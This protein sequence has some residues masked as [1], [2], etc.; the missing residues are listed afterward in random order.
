MKQK[1]L[2][3]LNEL[4]DVLSTKT[5]TAV[6]DYLRSFRGTDEQFHLNKGEEDEDLVKNIKKNYKKSN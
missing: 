2:K 4:V 3:A 6:K 1:K 5:P